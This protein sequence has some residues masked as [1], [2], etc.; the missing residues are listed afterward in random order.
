VSFTTQI[1]CAALGHNALGGVA[2]GNKEF[3]IP[4]LN[5]NYKCA[6]QDLHFHADNV[7]QVVAFYNHHV[8]IPVCVNMGD[9]LICGFGSRA[10]VVWAKL[11]LQLCTEARNRVLVYMPDKTLHEVVVNLEENKRLDQI[12][13]LL[14]AN[15]KSNSIFM[16]PKTNLTAVV[17]VFKWKQARNAPADNFNLHE[18]G[19]IWSELCPENSFLDAEVP[20]GEITEEMLQL[21]N[22]TLLEPQRLKLQQLQSCIKE[23]PPAD[24][25]SI[26]RSYRLHICD[27]RTSTVP[28]NV[29]ACLKRQDTT[30]TEW[31]IVSWVM[32]P[33]EVLGRYSGLGWLVPPNLP[34]Y[35]SFIYTGV[36]YYGYVVVF[37]VIW[38]VLKLGLVALEVLSYLRRLLARV[39]QLYEAPG[40]DEEPASD[41]S[42]T[43]V[44]SILVN[45]L[46]SVSLPAYWMFVIVRSCF[47]LIMNATSKIKRDGKKP[48]H[49]PYCRQQ[50]Q[51]GNDFMDRFLHEGGGSRRTFSEFR[52]TQTASTGKE[53]PNFGHVPRNQSV[54]PHIASERNSRQKWFLD[55]TRIFADD[56]KNDLSLLQEML[57]CGLPED[58]EQEEQRKR[59]HRQEVRPR[60]A[61]MDDKLRD[62]WVMQQRHKEAQ[63]SRA[64]G[65]QDDNRILDFS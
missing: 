21:C 60:Y 31:T 18:L 43:L 6:N 20:C 23:L 9:T 15:V 56:L 51:N 64:A 4:D 24:R 29:E 52:Q 1:L 61:S 26:E 65:N 44:M 35:L 3:S 39:V 37:V 55:N 46:Y 53:R 42:C 58:H 49:E 19:T 14:D 10:E 34:W 62:D 16:V 40:K 27:F 59:D 41:T 7:E 8:Q 33:F 32:I 47:R 54:Y 5:K 22:N 13:S 2:V 28:Q 45:F 48:K 50:G 30:K 38:N 11:Q 17:L 63:D 36:W 57:L 12:H 25:A